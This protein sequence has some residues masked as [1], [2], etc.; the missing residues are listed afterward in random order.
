MTKK[1]QIQIFEE[2]KSVQYGTMRDNSG[3]FLL[4][5]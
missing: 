2:K 5:M 1:Q 3:T 4:P